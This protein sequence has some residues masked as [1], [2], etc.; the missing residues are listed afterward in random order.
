MRIENDIKLSFDDIMLRPKRSNI[1][2]RSEVDLNREFTFVNSKNTW[3]GIPISSSNMDT[4]GTIPVYLELN[5]FNMLT[6]LHKYHTL[7]DLEYSLPEMDYRNLSLCTGIHNED[8]DRMNEIFNSNKFKNI[9]YICIDSPNGYIQA[10]V[11]FVKKVRDKYPNKNIIAGAVATGEITEEL[12]LSGADI[13][14]IGI[15][16][17]SVCTTVLKTAVSFPQVSAIMETQ[18]AA[19]GINGCIM[20]DGGIRNPSDLVKAFAAGAD[21]CMIG[22]LFSGTEE[23]SGD[24]IEKDGE[25]Y[26]EFYG[27]SSKEA[28]DKYHRGVANYKA[29][30]G[31]KV[32][33]PYK[34]EIKDIVQDLHGG[35]RSASAYIGA[36]KLKELSKRATFLK[37][38][39]QE[40]QV[41]N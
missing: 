36:K 4:I 7:K 8:F 26:K 22:G 15:G 32:L 10:F 14:K 27:M 23:S 35:L 29:A 1:K 2:S 20:A 9:P 33:V 40:N 5:K 28:M 6:V 12:I 24:I 17:G 21:F 37:V 30:E 13:V 16:V 18:D 31:K 11:D 19:H 38:T 25:F 34:G 39:Q 3:Q 41:F